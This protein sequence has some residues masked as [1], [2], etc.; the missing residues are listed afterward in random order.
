MGLVAM[1]MGLVGLPGCELWWLGQ[2]LGEGPDASTT[3]TCDEAGEAVV[4]IHGHSAE[5]IAFSLEAFGFYGSPRT[6]EQRMDVIGRPVAIDGVAGDRAFVK[7]RQDGFEPLVA[8]EF[9]WH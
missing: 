6:V 8:V 3:I 1:A 4:T 9:T 7:C 5:T 2:H